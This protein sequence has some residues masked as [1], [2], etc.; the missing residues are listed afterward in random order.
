MARRLAGRRG[1]CRRPTSGRGPRAR[2]S[3]DRRPLDQPAA[4]RVRRRR[5]RAAL[6]EPPRLG[7]AS[8]FRARSAALTR[9][10]AFPDPA[11]RRAA[12]SSCRA[13][14][15]AWHAGVSSWR[16][17]SDCNDFSIGIELEGLEG[18]VSTPRNTSAGTADRR[19]AGRYP[20]E[21]VVGHE[22]VA[23]VA[24]ATPGPASTGPFCGAGRGPGSGLAVAA[25]PVEPIG[26]RASRHAGQR[27]G[28]VS[29]HPRFEL[30]SNRSHTL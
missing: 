5:D 24:R 14:E 27:S 10:G 12:S 16:G 18:S 28:K 29:E 3:T 23:P 7:R 17:R 4:R 13:T 6:H 20:I 2:R 21:A 15:R 22:H 11:R 19:L 30:L 26:R 25:G 8:L 1:A 9:L